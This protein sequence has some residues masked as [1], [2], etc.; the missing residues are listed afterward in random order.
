MLLFC[1]FTSSF[2][3]IEVFLT[4]SQRFAPT[5]ILHRHT[6]TP[7]HKCTRANTHILHINTP[8]PAAPGSL[9]LSL[10]LYLSLSL[11]VSLSLP[12]SISLT[13]TNKHYIHIH[14]YTYI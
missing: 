11:S 5:R 9:S 10:S 8:A 6:D 14:T 2:D 12:P 3:T 4:V 1:A 7:T 13:H